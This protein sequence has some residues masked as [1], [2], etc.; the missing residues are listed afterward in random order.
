[1]GDS[2]SYLD[3]LL[4]LYFNNDICK[5]RNSVFTTAKYLYNNDDL[6]IYL[7]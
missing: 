3:N 2:L 6:S 4:V 1:M 7:N 5:R